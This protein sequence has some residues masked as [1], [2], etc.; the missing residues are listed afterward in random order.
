MLELRLWSLYGLF[1]DGV[2]N[3]DTLS[4]ISVSTRAVTLRTTSLVARSCFSD[5]PAKT[6]ASALA[7][8]WASAMLLAQKPV[9]GAAIRAAELAAKEKMSTSSSPW[10]SSMTFR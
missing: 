9:A 5:S 6:T 3:G 2:D 8:S 4:A 7:D 10:Q 1:V